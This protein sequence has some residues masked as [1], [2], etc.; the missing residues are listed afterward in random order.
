MFDGFTVRKTKELK[1]VSVIQVE[2]F[3]VQHLWGLPDK[4]LP[5]NGEPLHFWRS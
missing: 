3:T 2:G 4:R 5:F 1:P